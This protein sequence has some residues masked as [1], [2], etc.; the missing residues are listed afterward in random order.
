MFI[1]SVVLEKLMIS[2]LIFHY[3]NKLVNKL[4]SNLINLQKDSLT[5]SK[6]KIK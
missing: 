2:I 1:V 4:L 5:M 6:R 3:L